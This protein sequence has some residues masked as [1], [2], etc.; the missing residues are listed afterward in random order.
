MKVYRVAAGSD[1][2]LSVIH[3]NPFKHS[4][5]YTYHLLF[6]LKKLLEF[7]LR[8]VIYVFSMIRTID[9]DFLKQR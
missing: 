8:S 9:C 4:G 7:C 2:T 6:T 5:N 3:L 1:V